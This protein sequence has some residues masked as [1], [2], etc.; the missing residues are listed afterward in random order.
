M[1][2]AKEVTKATKSL[3]ASVKKIFE[4][5]EEQIKKEQIITQQKEI[6]Q[7][8]EII[9]QV[10]TTQTKIASIDLIG[11]ELINLNQIIGEPQLI[12]NDGKTMMVRFDQDKCRLFLFMNS[13]SNN[14]KIEYYEIRNNK[15]KI[16]DKKSEIEVCYKKIGLV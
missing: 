5:Q 3:E 13:K 7:E 16:I 14:P 8:Q 15:G 1:E 6:F 10:V 4:P 12:R 11:K 9:S 2:V